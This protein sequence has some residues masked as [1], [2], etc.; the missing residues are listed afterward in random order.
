M[1]DRA[2]A[3][4]GMRSTR[5]SNSELSNDIELKHFNRL[6]FAV[7]AGDSVSVS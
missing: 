2:K 6:K 1:G 5:D 3:S 4:L 7:R